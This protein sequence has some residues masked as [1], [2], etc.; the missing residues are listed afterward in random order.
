MRIVAPR[1]CGP[2]PLL[3]HCRANQTV[4]TECPAGSY[5][6]ELGS[7]Q[8]ILC[9]PGTYA[10]APGSEAC[11]LCPARTYRTNPDE[12]DIRN[13]TIATTCSLCPPGSAVNAQRTGCSPCSAGRYQVNDSCVDCNTTANEYQPLTNQSTCGVCAPGFIAATTSELLSRAALRRSTCRRAHGYCCTGSHHRCPP[14]P[15]PCAHH[16][17]PGFTIQRPMPA[18]ARPAFR[19]LRRVSPT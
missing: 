12:A 3:R 17:A 7:S 2:P 10:P 8:C 19:A 1:L 14:P 5:A 4:C 15:Q 9:P 11:I 6:D 13:A 16:A 18:S